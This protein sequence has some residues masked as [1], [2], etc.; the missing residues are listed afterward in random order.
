MHSASIPYA[1]RA[2]AY[3]L[4]LAG[5]EDLLK[6]G[7]SRDPLARWAA[8]HP[9]WFEAFDLERSL[10]VET[11]TRKDAQALETRLH[12]MLAEH[13]CPVP[14]TIREQ[15][16]G[17]TEWYRGAEAHARRFVEEC[18]REGYV[19]HMPA[20]PWLAAAMRAQ[21]E[22]IDGLVRQAHAEHCNGC[23]DPSRR[24]ALQDL[25]DAHRAFDPGIAGTWPLELLDDMRIR[26]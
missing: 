2:F 23:L 11:E 12:R 1:G 8:F 22:R 19:V 9:R 17:A 24:R 26:R 20:R 7:M 4:R 25:L 16:G 18:S 10:L 3:V 6:A 21:Q 15:A 14:M 13:A 5:A